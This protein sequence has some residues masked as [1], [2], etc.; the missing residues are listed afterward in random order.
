[1]SGLLQDYVRRQ[2][3]RRPDSV[4][5]VGDDELSYAQLCE[6]SS[7]L[8]LTLREAGCRT[9]DRVVLL[10][11]H[12]L[13]AVAA[14]LGVYEAGCIA[15]P[16]EPTGPAA[17]LVRALEACRPTCL[18][19][20]GRVATILD[21]LVALD[22]K[23]PAWS[24][25]WLGD[26]PA[27]DHAF[28]LR[29]DLGD[30]R[31][32]S[33]GPGAARDPDDPAHILYTSGSTGTPKGIVITHAN[34]RHFVDWGVDHFGIREDD[35][36][37]SH[38]RLHFDLATF[39]LFGTF[40][41]GASLHI[42]PAQAN[43]L[44]QKLAGFIRDHRLTQWFSVPG[45][46]G[47]L[48]RFDAL[49]P[50]DFPDLRRVIWCGEVL[51]TPTLAYW[52]ERLPHATFTNLYGPTEATI[53]STWYTV[54]GTPGELAAD[55]PI[56]RPCSDE[57]VLVLDEDL[58]PVAPG[59]TGELYIGGPG[60]SPGYWKNPERTARAFLPHPQRPRERLYRTGD[61]G[62]RDED[63]LLYFAGR[64]D[65][66]IKSRGYRI[67]LGEIEQAMNSLGLVAECAVVPLQTSGF[68]GA[69]ICCAFAGF[70]ER[71]PSEKQLRRAL[72]EQIPDYML[73]TRWLA[74]ERLPTNKNGKVDRPALVRVFAAGEGD[75]NAPAA[76]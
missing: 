15:V 28:R 8:A 23:D 33:L 5:V 63:G 40:A 49:E 56:G 76:A 71:R 59:E 31:R 55:I 35:R 18:L 3:E 58:R 45:V 53:A 60:L 6:L 43:V 36:N 64:V 47:Y 38:T 34:A 27:D 11:P 17:R 61:L 2:A 37:S 70:P 41:A 73:P 44:P 14:L 19:G 66:Q 20:A 68:E 72:R 32:A 7:R 21:D 16:L 52:M 54:P 26:D 67:E 10:M 22:G 46:L 50:G 42:V 48:R 24:V 51:P 13:M 65:S 62:R 12:S 9:G 75:G 57:E 25:G 30:V 69:R 4:A 29:F 1:M 39:D 74:M